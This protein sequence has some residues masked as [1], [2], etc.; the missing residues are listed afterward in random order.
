MEN[1]LGTE[2]LRSTDVDGSVPPS[3]HR[4][5]PNG[6]IQPDVPDSTGRLN[7]ALQTAL[8]SQI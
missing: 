2:C 3:C 5:P 4:E 6:R 7:E 8:A 1:G